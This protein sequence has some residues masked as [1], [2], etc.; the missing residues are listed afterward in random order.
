[1]QSLC[2]EA[3]GKENS[4]FQASCF[5]AGRFHFA[6]VAVKSDEVH[7][8]SLTDF[9]YSVSERSTSHSGSIIFSTL[10]YFSIKWHKDQLI[11]CEG[12]LD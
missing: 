8:V 12:K 1:M 6:E 4:R 9:E 11:H 3:G 7:F 5:E 2:E 10:G